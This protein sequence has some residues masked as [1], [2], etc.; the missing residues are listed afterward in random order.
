MTNILKGLVCDCRESAIIIMGGSGVGRNSLWQDILKGLV[1]D[2]RESAIIIMG[3][4]GV[5]RNSL[6]QDILKRAC[7]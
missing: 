7:V 6:W 3:G 1:C 4:S 5:G 2:C